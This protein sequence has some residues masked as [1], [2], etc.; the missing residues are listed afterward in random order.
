MN[1]N[2]IKIEEVR[3]RQGLNQKE[4]AN[5]AGLSRQWLSVILLRGSATT[6]AAIK[7]A[8][9]LEVPLQEILEG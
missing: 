8:D 6:E 4:L 9:A 1:L 2:C 5:K 3:V 7:I